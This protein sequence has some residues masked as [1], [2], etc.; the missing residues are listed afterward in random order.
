MLVR[1][2]KCITIV[3]LFCKIWNLPSDGGVAFC[4]LLP[5]V[6]DPLSL[7]FN[8]FCCR[9]LWTKQEI[10]TMFNNKR[11]V[12]QTE[13]LTITIKGISPWSSKDR[14]ICSRDPNG[15]WPLFRSFEI[16]EGCE[17]V[18][19]QGNENMKNKKE[20]NKWVMY[21]N[22]TYQQASSGLIEM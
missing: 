20:R 21:E 13:T 3:K 12:P 19:K 14:I 5:D 18:T 9:F 15:G 4:T 10:K 22:V 1:F 6:S 17:M 11:I 7:S 2:S 8:N 16:F